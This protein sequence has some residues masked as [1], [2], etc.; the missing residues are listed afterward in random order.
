MRTLFLGV[1]SFALAFAGIT[2]AADVVDLKDVKCLVNPKA[3]AK[4][5]KSS[6]WKDGKVFFCC[7]NCLGKFEG[8]KKAMASKANHQLIASK[9]VEQTA[10][11]MS[12]VAIKD[13]KKVEFK[14]A[15]VK[16]CCG[17]CLAAAEKMSDEEKLDGLFGEKAYEKAKYTKV[18]KKD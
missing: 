12:G 10:C 4:A 18:E 2:F 16:F 8:D 13:D 17:N 6:E 11:P 1:A 15:T 3:A 7:S 14:G 5:D 9:Q